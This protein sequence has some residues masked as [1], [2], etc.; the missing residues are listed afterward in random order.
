[1]DSTTNKSI[2]QSINREGVGSPYLDD[3]RDNIDILKHFPQLSQS[4]RRIRLSH[5][6][7]NRRWSRGKLKAGIIRTC[8]SAAGRSAAAAA[9]IPRR[10]SR[11]QV[12]H[13][14]RHTESSK[15]KYHNK[16]LCPEFYKPIF[17]LEN[18]A[19]SGHIYRRLSE[20]S[21]EMLR[22]PLWH[23]LLLPDADVFPCNRPAKA[24]NA[25]QEMDRFDYRA[26][27]PVNF[28]R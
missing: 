8:S 14:N 3:F 12:N 15:E 17:C 16:G 13:Q 27:L 6:C 26:W 10:R 11:G 19:K 9:V 18:F 7:R 28:G 24:S 22:L 23:V 5:F 21:N 2:N 4:F 20:D 1:M 25:Y